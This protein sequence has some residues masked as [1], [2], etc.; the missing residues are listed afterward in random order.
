LSPVFF[1]SRA[2][3]YVLRVDW[4]LVHRWDALVEG[5]LLE[6]PDAQ[7]R[8]SGVLVGIYRQL[9]NNIRTGIGYNFSRFSDDLTQLDYKHQG[10]FVNV[11]GQF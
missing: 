6:L 2:H 5:R 11:I 1:D 8:L 4:H 9:N 3:L 7:D 10:L